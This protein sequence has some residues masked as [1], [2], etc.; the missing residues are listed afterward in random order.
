MGSAS[1]TTTGADQRYWDALAE[2][3]LE[4]PRCRGCGRWNWPAVWR[5]GDCGG[6]HHEWVET[7]L[8]GAI[9][10]WTRT[11]HPFGGLESIGIPLVIVVVALDGANHTRMAGILEGDEQGVRVG[12]RAEGRVGET[13][14]AGRAI[15]ALR[16]RLAPH[17]PSSSR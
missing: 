15:P 13:P 10:T 3:Q 2:G 9:F 1:H 4:L 5:C 7:P 17:A 12:A 14:F 11:W 6:W 16:W 8:S